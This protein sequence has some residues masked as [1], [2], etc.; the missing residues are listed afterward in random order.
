MLIFVLL[1]YLYPSL[2]LLRWN[3]ILLWMAGALNKLNRGPLGPCITAV[4]NH[5]KDMLIRW[6]RIL[7]RIFRLLRVLFFFVLALDIEFARSSLP[8]MSSL[9][10]ARASFA[11]IGEL[12]PSSFH[13]HGIWMQYQLQFIIKLLFLLLKLLLFHE[14]L[15]DFIPLHHSC[16]LV[17]I[18]LNCRLNIFHH[19]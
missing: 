2:M 1:N 11:V 10:I 4:I 7:S 8:G 16:V 9:A 12:M 14:Q 19:L 6:M 17:Q 18:C 13:V 5:A 15:I 3:C